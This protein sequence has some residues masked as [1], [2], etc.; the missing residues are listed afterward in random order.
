M[1][2]VL[3]GLVLLGLSAAGVYG[4]TLGERERTY[5]RLVADGDA[6]L[7]RDDTS[8]AVEAF[9]GVALIVPEVQVSATGTDALLLGL[10]I[11]LTVI[12]AALGISVLV[13]VQLPFSA[14]AEQVAWLAV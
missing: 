6:A 4:Y 8:A 13:M 11:L 10:K 12:V 5:R 9:S 14:T 7:A 2:R 3:A 1:K